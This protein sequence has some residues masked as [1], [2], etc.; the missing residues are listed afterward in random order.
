MVLNG[1]NETL[2][3]HSSISGDNFHD[4]NLESATDFSW[5][6]ARDVSYHPIMRKIDNHIAKNYPV[7]NVLFHLY[8]G[9]FQIFVSRPELSF[10]PPLI[11]MFSLK[12]YRHLTSNT[13]KTKFITSLPN[14]LI[15]MQ[16]LIL[17]K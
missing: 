7:Q 4:H 2:K 10:K 14:Q 15:P 13:Y 5:M 6:D 9:D 1:K 11:H 8:I 17:Q 3:G 12:F 16:S